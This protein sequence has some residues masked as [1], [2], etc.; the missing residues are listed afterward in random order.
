MMEQMYLEPGDTSVRTKM[1]AFWDAW[2]ELSMYPADTAPRT[3][4]VERGKTLI[5][6]IHNRYQGT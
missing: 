5:D 4:V 6:G 1:D 3:A 2:Q